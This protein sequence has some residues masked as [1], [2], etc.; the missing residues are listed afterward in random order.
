MKAAA[1]A[2]ADVERQSTLRS[3]IAHRGVGLHSGRVVSLRLL[4][5]PAGTGL[6]F[7]LMGANQ[8]VVAAFS[9]TSSAVLSSD[10]ATTLGEGRDASISTVEHLLAVLS[11]CEIDNLVIESE[12]G[13]LPAFDGSARPILDWVRSGGRERQTARRSRWTVA[14]AW[15]L[16]EG[17]LSISIEPADRLSVEYAIDFDHPAIR[18]QSVALEGLDES[19]FEREVAGARTFGFESEINELQ[20]AGLGLGGSLDNVVVLGERAVL[21]PEGLRFPNEFARHKVIDLL[22]DLALLGRPLAGRIR[23]ERGGHALHHRFVAELL[24]TDGLLVPVQTAR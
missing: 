16:T 14:R 20:A 9:A 7:R 17:D 18:R 22:G 21:N 2:A 5:A 3:P 12:V 11:M 10:R 24:A 19:V 15:E 13:E 23:V 6:Q 4:P 8:E 1:S